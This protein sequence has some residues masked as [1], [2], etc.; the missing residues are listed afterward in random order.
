MSLNHQ[1]NSITCVPS[2]IQA[3]VAK[4][5]LPTKPEFSQFAEQL[6]SPAHLTSS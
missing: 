6:P 5:T 1:L 3:V 2:K 4:A